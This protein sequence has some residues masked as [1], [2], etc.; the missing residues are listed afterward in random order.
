MNDALTN[1]IIE[2]E[3]CK[4]MAIIMEIVFTDKQYCGSKRL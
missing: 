1:L 2:E 4:M 3:D